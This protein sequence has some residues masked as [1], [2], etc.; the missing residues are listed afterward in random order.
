M[1]KQFM[2]AAEAA[3]KSGMTVRR[4]QQLCQAG[5]VKGAQQFGRAWMIPATFTWRPQ[6]PGPKPK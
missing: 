1:P 2:T 4:I 3:E 6:K 5:A